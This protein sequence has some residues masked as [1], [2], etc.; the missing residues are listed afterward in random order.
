LFHTPHP[1]DAPFRGSPSEYW[2]K[3]LC[4][5]IEWCGYSMVKKSL[6][7]RLFISTQYT[8][9]ADIRQTDRQ[10]DNGRRHRPRLCRHRAAKTVVVTLPE[11]SSVYYE[12]ERAHKQVMV[13]VGADMPTWTIHSTCVCWSHPRYNQR[14]SSVTYRPL[15]HTFGSIADIRHARI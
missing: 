6:R 2:H 3:V 12:C 1:F 15:R 14:Q 4:G 7:I 11:Q 10:T 13:Q 8:N 5:K 9:V